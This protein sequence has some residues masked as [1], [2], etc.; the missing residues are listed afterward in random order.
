MLKRQ[1]GSSEPKAGGDHRRNDSIGNQNLR[2][3]VNHD[4]LAN[5]RHIS[6]D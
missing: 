6:R 4:D 3:S 2:G 1:K 5:N